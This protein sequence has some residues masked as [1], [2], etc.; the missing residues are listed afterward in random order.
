[1]LDRMSQEDR[2]EH[3][4]GTYVRETEFIKFFQPDRSPILQFIKHTLG[5]FWD[6]LTGNGDDEDN[7][8]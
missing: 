8:S 1:M 4:D 6:G 5:G 3:E 7:D 2:L